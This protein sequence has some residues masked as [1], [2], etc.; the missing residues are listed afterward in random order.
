MEIDIEKIRE[1]D[2]KMKIMAQYCG[3]EYYDMLGD[4]AINGESIQSAI[5]TCWRHFFGDEKI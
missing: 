3:N 5:D 4:L 2:I 1:N